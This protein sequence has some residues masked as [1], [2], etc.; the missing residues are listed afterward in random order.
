M[1]K[2]DGADRYRPARLLRVPALPRWRAH[3]RAGRRGG[4]QSSPS[5]CGRAPLR[6]GQAAQITVER[7]RLSRSE[8]EA[9]REAL[10]QG[11]RWIL[12]DEYQDIGPGEYALIAAV[13]GR[14]LDDPDQRLSLFAVG[15]EDQNIY[16][17][18]GVAAHLRRI[19]SRRLICLLPISTSSLPGKSPKSTSAMTMK[20]WKRSDADRSGIHRRL[21]QPEGR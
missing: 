21:Q 20:S 16:A 1:T 17:F 8:A 11:Y 7:R 4:A 18:T 9:Q 13:A 2:A 3:L 12:V 10:I 19:C 5:S 15:D 6:R 14:S